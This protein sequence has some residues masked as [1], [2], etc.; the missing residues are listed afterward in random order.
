VRERE[1]ERESVRD[2]R[3]AHS[4]TRA[5]VLKRQAAAAGGRFIARRGKVGPKDI[6]NSSVCTMSPSFCFVQRQVVLKKFNE[7]IKTLSPIIQHHTD[8]YKYRSTRTA[9][10]KIAAAGKQ[11]VVVVST[12]RWVLRFD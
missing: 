8:I 9:K 5:S 3:G 11:N 1:R 7:G 10:H 6:A 12:G 2:E 4:T